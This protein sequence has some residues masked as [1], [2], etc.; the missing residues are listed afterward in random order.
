M[1]VFG[2][3]EILVEV[4]DYPAAHGLAVKAL[5]HVDAL[6]FRER[7]EFVRALCALRAAQSFKH[8]GYQRLAVADE[9]GVDEGRERLRRQSAGPS[10]EYQRAVLAAPLRTERNPREVEYRQYVRVRELV[11]KREADGV[12]IAQAALA[13]ERPYRRA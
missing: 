7:R 4:L 8:V 5:R 2:T 6:D 1:P 3:I 12:E 10:R 13:F 9:E 11:L